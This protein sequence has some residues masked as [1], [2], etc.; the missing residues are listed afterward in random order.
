MLKLIMLAAISLTL[1][2]NTIEFFKASKENEVFCKVAFG[3]YK[4]YSQRNAKLV[5]VNKQVFFKVI[6][7]D[8]YIHPTICNPVTNKEEVILF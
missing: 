2:A 5:S 6:G 4:I 8:E 3:K 7:Q 1:S